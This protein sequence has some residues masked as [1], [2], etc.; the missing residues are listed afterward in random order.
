MDKL[1]AIEVQWLKSSLELKLASINR[2]RN[3]QPVGS[4]IRN[5]LT[6]DAGF[7]S[8]LIQKVQS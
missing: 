6:A 3:S 8:A 2:M 7:V 4:D 5:A 1:S